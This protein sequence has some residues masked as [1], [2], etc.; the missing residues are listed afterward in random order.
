M[1]TYN[2]SK[3]VIDIRQ[4]RGLGSNWVVRVYRKRPLFRKRISTDWFLDATQARDF[5]DELRSSL[6]RPETAGLLAGR[7]PGWILRRPAH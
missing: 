6:D 1:P 4:D 5:V 3:H 7:R 2:T